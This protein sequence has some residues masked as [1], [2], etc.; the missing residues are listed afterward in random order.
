MAHW[1]YLVVE[2]LMV[3]G[4]V[5][6]GL[7][8]WSASMIVQLHRQHDI[9]L[10]LLHTMAARDSLTQAVSKLLEQADAFRSPPEP[11]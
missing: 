10:H 7:A 1:I 11:K 5:S 4:L 8:V 2:L 6:I 3:G 9:S